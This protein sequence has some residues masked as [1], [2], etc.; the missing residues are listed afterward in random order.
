MSKKRQPIVLSMNARRSLSLPAVHVK[1]ERSKNE[2]MPN[3]Y[4]VMAAPAYVPERD[5]DTRIGLARI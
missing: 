4:N 5:L 1:R 2:A 3:T